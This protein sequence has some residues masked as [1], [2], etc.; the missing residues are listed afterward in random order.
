MRE[1]H[2]GPR[3]YLLHKV[4]N[5]E[6]ELKFEEDFVKLAPLSDTVLHRKTLPLHAATEDQPAT[7][8]PMALRVSQLAYGR[9]SSIAGHPEANVCKRLLKEMP[10]DGFLTAGGPLLISETPIDST[11][12]PILPLDLAPTAAARIPAAPL[13]HIKGSA[14]TSTLL[15]LLSML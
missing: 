13:G 14:R 1:T 11:L 3:Q 7:T 2:G 12:G 8:T 4:R 9:E 15:A 5:P 10:T 6:A